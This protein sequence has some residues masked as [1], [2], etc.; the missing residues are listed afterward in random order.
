MLETI[1]QDFEITL[2]LVGIGL[3]HSQLSFEETARARSKPHN[4]RTL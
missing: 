4:L 3:L 1:I 2:V